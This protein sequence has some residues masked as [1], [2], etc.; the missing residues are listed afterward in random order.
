MHT[1]TAQFEAA[2]ADILSS[3]SDN[4]TVALIVVRPQKNE[5]TTPQSVWLTLEEGI[6]GDRWLK[7]SGITESGGSGVL[8]ERTGFELSC[9]RAR[10][11]ESS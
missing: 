11:D 6:Q 10:A 8:D 5:R 7:V 9:W 1:T 4:G 2:L 3:P